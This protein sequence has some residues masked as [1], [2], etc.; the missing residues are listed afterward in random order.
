[1]DRDAP[2]LQAP[3]VTLGG[4]T[5]ERDVVHGPISAEQKLDVI[6]HSP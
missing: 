1:V 4:E 5:V 2:T 6:D 3:Y